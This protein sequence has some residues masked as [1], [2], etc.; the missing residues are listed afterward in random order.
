ML[1]GPPHV[2]TKAVI[3]MANWTHRWYRSDG[4]LSATQIA[5]TFVQTFLH[6][7]TSPEETT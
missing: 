6:G 3:G 7:V 5:D 2:L 1:A 4:A